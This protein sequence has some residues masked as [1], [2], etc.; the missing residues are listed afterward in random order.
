MAILTEEKFKNLDTDIK[1]AGEAINEDKLINPRYG[2]PFNSFPRAI[3]IMMENGGWKPYLTEAALLS[4]VPLVTPSM[5]Y[6][7]DTMKL[8]FWDGTKWIVGGKS[9]LEQANDFTKSSI[10]GLFNEYPKQLVLAPIFGKA[11]NTSTPQDN[12]FSSVQNQ[13][14]AY[15]QIDVSNIVR[16]EVNNATSNFSAWKWVFCDKNG[17]YISTST[18]WGSGTYEVP[19]GAKW[20]YR[21]YQVGDSNAYENATII[22]KAIIKFR[23][24]NE[25]NAAI[26]ENNIL[27]MSQLKTYV[28]D[29]IDGD[30][31]INATNAV[32]SGYAV[33]TTPGSLN[34][35][36]AQNGDIRKYIEIDV[37]RYSVLKVKNSL[38]VASWLWVFVTANGQKILS[39]YKLDG[40]F[41]IPVSAVKA[42]RTVYYE[43][44]TVKYDD[45]NNG[46]TISG[47]LR[48][49]PTEQR[50]LNLETLSNQLNSR[51]GVLESISGVG[52][53]SDS[54]RIRRRAMIEK[55]LD[56]F[57]LKKFISPNDFAD[58]TQMDRLKSSISFVKTQG[59]GIIEL[60]Q[61]SRDNT[62]IWTI[63]ESLLLP[64]NCWIYINN[65]TLKKAA[66]VF[67]TMIRNE[68]IV[69]SPN[70]FEPALELYPNENIWIFGNDKM[71]SVVEGNIDAP[72]TA[73]HPVKGGNPIPFI[74]DLFG[75]RTLSFLFANT[76]GHRVFNLSFKKTTCW[77]NSN[78]HGCEDF[79]FHDLYFDTTVKNG[80][81]VDVRMGCQDFEIYNISGTTSDDMIALTAIHRYAVQHPWYEYVYPIQV[82]GYEDRGLGIDIKNG[83][84]WNVRGKNSNGGIRLLWTGGSKMQFI[85][86]D[87]I[88]DDQ[89][90]FKYYVV[91]VHTGQ[92]GV[93]AIRGD[94]NNITINKVISNFTTK[95][96]VKLDGPLKD[97]WI[98]NIVQNTISETPVVNKGAYYSEDN[99]KITN[100]RQAK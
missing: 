5:G 67:D 56:M 39:E 90:G 19:S 64:D 42:Y 71:L 25:V 11:I 51:V 84:I 44:G 38:N 83:R 73:V 29:V 36:T 52:R 100:T 57:N 45:I 10:E 34:L 59:Y 2:A 30:E 98:N 26:S 95:D 74:G 22:I 53:E 63:T 33:D 91:L 47:A 32:R 89:V 81:G 7:Y 23:I 66:G 78:E 40:S 13:T 58:L 92:Y 16:L 82:G 77:A 17:V 4:T 43:K 88:A 48:V 76:K 37:S 3:R 75:W 65:S 80:D 35:L 72:Y 54:A 99:V 9:P 31:D 46:L 86:V 87:D 70:P 18:T 69:P 79:K 41:D 96:V 8:Y 24:R 28:K 6:A 94:S 15:L 49:K 60:A 62:N 27:L 21:T 55:M 68:G 1:H 14:R 97:T 61:D 20:A 12:L 85:S 50:F 93:P